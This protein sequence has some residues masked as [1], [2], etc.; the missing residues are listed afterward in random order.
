[1][2]NKHIVEYL[3]YY[4]GSEH[5]NF[6]VL[7]KGN[8]GS[9]KTYFIRN[10]IEI[11]NTPNIA[12]D[13]FIT[14]NPIYISLN[15]INSK[16]EIIEKLREKLNPFFHS[17]GVKVATAIFKGFIKSTLKIDFD[18]NN[19][20][21]NDGSIN[22]NFDPISIFREDN[23][24]IK[25][26]R[27]LIFDDIER[28]K[29]SVDEVYGFINDFVEHSKCKVIL[30]S[31]EDKIIEKDKKEKNIIPYTSFKEKIVGQ[32]FEISP[33]SEEAIE[34]FITLVTENIQN[35]L[36]ENKNL[37]FK[38]FNTTENKN[39]RVLQRAFFDFQR[40]MSLVNP[41]L[42]KDEEKFKL[43]CK[44]LLA[45]Y[46]IFHIEYNTGNLGIENF[47]QLFLSDEKK[48]A[49]QNYEE[50]IK[51]DNLLHS[52][53]I[54]TAQN[55]IQYISK[56]NYESLITEINN[57]FIFNSVEERDWEKLWYWK[58]LDD[59]V[60]SEILPK[61]EIDFFEKE[62]FDYTEVLHIAGIF[63]NL[64]D[65]DIYKGKSKTDFVARSKYIFT[66]TKELEKIQNLNLIARGSWRKSY[67]S[68]Q[69]IEFQE[70]FNF[71]KECIK[72]SQKEYSNA[73]IENII[74]GLNN[75]N[76]DEL[77]DV[78][79]N[80]DWS[81]NKILERTPI[82]K[83]IS[84]DTFSKT[85]L[86]L[87]NKAIF[88]LNGYL[89]YRYYPENT[90]SNLNIENYHRE[91]LDFIIKLRTCLMDQL[92]TLADKPIRLKTLKNFID[93]LEKIS[94]RLN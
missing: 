16:K 46:L 54:F 27:I 21:G 92:Q 71:L 33:N 61:V 37:V 79:K 89:N 30:I 4:I 24:N 11:W 35:I 23:E 17:K 28:C 12:E 1:M 66:Q 83:N 34:Y 36:L 22:L 64:I 74:Y 39:L 91:E 69:T 49:F 75:D 76:I 26:N 50:V 41:E 78:F 73:S 42:Q 48:Y 82:F 55:L 93:D 9:G 57:C 2:N 20:G 7:L 38:I 62:D 94:L 19:D 67:A 44:S 72:K 77:Y 51:S 8:W 56:G 40:L 15:G 14:I 52:T 45:Y 53:K 47:Q 29:M 10:L 81:T 65:N 32:V 80:Y 70:I 25:G 60:F 3:N 68:E 6:A 88:E 18:Y 13:Q 63:L 87:N 84:A 90:F 43:L 59:E 31:D 85:I 5:V 86:N 58:F